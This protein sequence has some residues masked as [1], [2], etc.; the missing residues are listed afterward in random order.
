MRAKHIKLHS[1]RSIQI[2]YQFGDPNPVQIRSIAFETHSVWV[3]CVILPLL[4]QK[5]EFALSVQCASPSVITQGE[6][7]K[8]KKKKEV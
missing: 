6:R 1:V 7:E 2:L 4:L 3:L 8:E 5:N